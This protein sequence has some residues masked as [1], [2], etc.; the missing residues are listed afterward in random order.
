MKILL[1]I[2]A[3][4]TFLFSAGGGLTIIGVAAGHPGSDS[5]V[6]VAVGMAFIGLGIFL[7]AILLFAAE[8]LGRKDAGK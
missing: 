1:R 4:L 2:A 6:V 7:G 8:R 3:G 5:L